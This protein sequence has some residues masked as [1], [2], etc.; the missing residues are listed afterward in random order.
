MRNEL[1]SD[2]VA[3]GERQSALSAVARG[4]D[5]CRAAVSQVE[6]FVHLVNSAT[7]SSLSEGASRAYSAGLWALSFLV[8]ASGGCDWFPF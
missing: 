8:E 5:A 7:S 6:A 3:Q 2:F 1:S 4:L